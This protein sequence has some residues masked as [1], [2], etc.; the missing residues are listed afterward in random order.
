MGNLLTFDLILYL[1]YVLIT[2]LK[3]ASQRQHSVQV[4]GLT[5]EKEDL[6]NQLAQ[7]QKQLDEVSDS[8]MT[9][10]SIS[11]PSHKEH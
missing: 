9:Y 8:S 2:R 6:T 5:K 10:F 7:L 3:N 4:S 1:K 11:G